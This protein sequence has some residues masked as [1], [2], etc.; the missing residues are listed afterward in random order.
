MQFSLFVYFKLKYV[1]GDM[2]IAGMPK[3]RQ[4]VSWRLTM[5]A[6]IDNGGRD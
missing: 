2:D 6:E 1:E 5:M 3:L 4:N